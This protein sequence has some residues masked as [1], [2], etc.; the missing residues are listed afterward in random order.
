LGGTASVNG[1]TCA[2]RIELPPD[3]SV[4]EKSRD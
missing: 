4:D 2:M 3:W 1:A